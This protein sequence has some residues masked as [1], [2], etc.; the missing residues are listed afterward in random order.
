MIDMRN[1]RFT[2]LILSK[3][4]FFVSIGLN[5]RFSLS[6]LIGGTMFSYDEMDSGGLTGNARFGN[7][8]LFD[9]LYLP[10]N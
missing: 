5:C 3:S 7:V 9:V 10:V 1:F 8:G 4:S 6:R 2:M